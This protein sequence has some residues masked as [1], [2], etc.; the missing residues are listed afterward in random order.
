[1]QLLHWSPGFAGWRRSGCTQG[2]HRHRAEVHQRED[3]HRHRRGDGL[4]HLDRLV[5][6]HR[7]DDYRAHHRGHQDLVVDQ[8]VSPGIR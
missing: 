6:D 8:A 2:V 5:L 4:G 1:M 7:E 3:D